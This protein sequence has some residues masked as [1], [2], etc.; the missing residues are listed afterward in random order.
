MTGI[1]FQYYSADIRDT[2]P[3]GDL[4]LWQFLMAIR[5]P[6]PHIIE[7]FD[8]IR[9]ADKDR[10]EATKAKL[11][12]HLYYFTPA[13]MVDECRC[14]DSIREFTGLMVLDF[15]KLEPAMAV[16]LKTD[17]MQA[18]NFI[19]ASWLSASGRGVRAL[20]N[21]PQVSTVDE[22]K[23][24][25]SG[26]M[27]LTDLGKIN[28]FDRAPQNP[29]LPLFMSYDPDIQFADTPGIWETPYHPCERPPIKQY[30]FEH[31]PTRVER[32]IKSAIDR[33]TD[34]GHPQLRAAAFRLGGYVGAG[35]I[36]REEAV[37][38]ITHMIEANAYLSI[39]PDVYKKTAKTMIDK[40]TEK[41]L[42]LEYGN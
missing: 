24:L 9:K 38:M 31:S 5:E 32:L 41:P 6:K 4:D 11:K 17:L 15:D 40:G 7:V 27:H 35:Y 20:V 22:Y 37:N 3:L 13:V 33:I 28:G 19:I 14:Y 18:Y 1:R 16:E 12:T 23:A 8:R 29:V 26:L 21:I 10:D 36:D 39:K 2:R 25:F 30:K 34:N 42:Y